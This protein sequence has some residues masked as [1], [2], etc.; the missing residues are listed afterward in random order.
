METD[1]TDVLVHY[2]TKEDLQ[3]VL[4]EVKTLR[5]EMRA[6]RAELMA[7]MRTLRAEFMTDMNSLRA[8]LFQ[9]LIAQTW[10]M[11]ALVVTVNISTVTAVYY[12]AQG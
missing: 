11:V 10:K 8:D 3:V 6:M 2:A 1:K 7:E 9:A 4:G 5:A 12:I